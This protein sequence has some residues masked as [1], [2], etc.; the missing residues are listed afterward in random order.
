MTDAT[1][2]FTLVRVVDA[3]PERIWSA[4]TSADEAAQWWHPRGFTTP[5]ESVTIDARVGGAFSYTMVNDATGVEYVTVGDY[6]EVTAP[7]KLVF[8]WG[9]TDAAAADLPVITVSIE[10]LGE[11]SRITFDLRGHEGVAGD[12]DFYDGWESAL[13]ELVQYLG[14]NEVFG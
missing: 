14:Q 7:E 2:G 10:S 13:D 12:G 3:T 8:G 4:W 5:R 1:P 9:G 6:R 11:L